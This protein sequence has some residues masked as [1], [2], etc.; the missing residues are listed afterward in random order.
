MGQIQVEATKICCDNRST[1]SITKNSTRHGRTKHMDI[2]FHFIRGLVAE[3]K[4]TLNIV[5]LINKWLT[6]S[7]S[8][9]PFTN[10]IISDQCQV[11]VGLI[12]GG[13]LKDDQSSSCNGPC[14]SQRGK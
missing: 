3:E 7:Q 11:F 5:V 9:F 14:G 4:I 8:H 6:Y 10:T 12:Q 1:I 2:R 13:V